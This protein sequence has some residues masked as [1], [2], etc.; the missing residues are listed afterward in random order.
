MWNSV[1]DL[2]S[3]SKYILLLKPV[4]SGVRYR[5]CLKSRLGRRLVSEMKMVEH[6]YTSAIIPN[7]AYYPTLFVRQP[8]QI[9][10]RLELA[11]LGLY[12]TMVQQPDHPLPLWSLDCSLPLS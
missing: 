1:G 7:R 11:R 9:N 12:F 5:S 6:Q 2:T 8:I 3:G 4:A 10:H